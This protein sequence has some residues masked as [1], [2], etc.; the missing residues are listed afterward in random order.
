MNGRAMTARR[1]SPLRRMRLLALAAAVAGLGAM[2]G[3]A[4]SGLSGSSTPAGDVVGGGGK[5]DELYRQIY[6]PGRG[7]D[8]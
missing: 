2:P 3:C 7:T 5:T 4:Q 1:P 8:F 6:T